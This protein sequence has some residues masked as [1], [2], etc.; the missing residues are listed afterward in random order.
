MACH[1]PDRKE[2]GAL[3]AARFTTHLRMTANYDTSVRDVGTDSLL[4]LDGHE[5]HQVAMLERP[6]F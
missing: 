2:E 3:T 1:A 6:S 4:L 5:I